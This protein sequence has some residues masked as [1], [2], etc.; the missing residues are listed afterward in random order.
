MDLTGIDLDRDCV[1][2]MAAKLSDDDAKKLLQAG[3]EG[4]AELSAEGEALGDEMF[5]CVN[6][7]T[8]VDSIL[9]GLPDDGSIDRDCMREQL[10]DISDPNDIQSK[11]TSAVVE[12]MDLGG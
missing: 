6:M 2:K 8:F 10:K 3:T 12:C 11:A 5:S 1:E 4:D 9:A 7:D